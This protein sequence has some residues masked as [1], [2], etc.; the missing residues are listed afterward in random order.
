MITRRDFLRMTSAAG[1]AAL[2]ATALVACG[3][4]RGSAS[5]AGAGTAANSVSTGT[6]ASSSVAATSDSIVV[7][8]SRANENYGVGIVEQG[9]T[10]VLAEIIAEKTGSDTFEVQPATAYPAGYDECCDVALDEQNAGARP[11]YV[12][13]VDLAPYKTVYLGYPI[14]WGDLPMC[15]YAFLESHDWADKDIKPFCTHEGSGVSGTDSAIASTCTGAAVDA[16]LSMTGTAAQTER[17]A[18]ESAVEAWLG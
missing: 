9:N 6:E 10:A 2:S 5:S 4:S 13:D 17:L 3:A 12:G 8:F 7:F 11:A 16:P 1:A 14:W 15:M 18:A